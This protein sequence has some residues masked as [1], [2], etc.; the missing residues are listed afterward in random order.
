MSMFLWDF[1]LFLLVV[2][3]LCNLRGAGDATAVGVAVDAGIDGVCG[4]IGAEFTVG[5]ETGVVFVDT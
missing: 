4:I 2:G 1:F 5:D 3:I